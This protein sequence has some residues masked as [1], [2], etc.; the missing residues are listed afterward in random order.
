MRRRGNGLKGER[1]SSNTQIPYGTVTVLLSCYAFPLRHDDENE[2]VWRDAHHLP[3][4]DPLD[5]GRTPY[6]GKDSCQI[7][8]HE[9][10]FRSIHG[11]L[12]TSTHCEWNDGEVLVHGGLLQK[13]Y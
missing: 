7:S 4:L 1:S 11:C 13:L 12:E 2:V 8:K 6:P 3:F 10:S 5:E 9:L